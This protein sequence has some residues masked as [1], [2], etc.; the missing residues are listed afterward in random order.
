MRLRD[1][2]EVDQQGLIADAVNL[3]MMADDS[4]NLSLCQGFIFNY[5]AEKQKTSTLGVLDAL[6]E[7]FHSANSLNVHLMV[8][9]FGK[10][11]SHFALTLAN[12]FKKPADSPEVQGIL[13][14]VDLAVSGTANALYEKLKAYKQRSKT[15][16]V[17]CISGEVATDL[18]KMLLQG[19]RNALEEHGIGDAI[20]QHIIQEPL[21]YLR[22]LAG[23]KR[24]QAE[25][26]LEE[27]GKP[28]GDLESMT[29]LLA[30]DNYDIIPTVVE[31]SKQLETYAFNFEYNLDIEKIL[32]DVVT[33]LCTG[34][35]RR[36]EGVLILLDEINA[37]LRAWLKNSK[38]AGGAALQNITNVCERNRGRIALLC[39]AQ[40]KPSLDNQIPYLERKSYER[41]TTRIELAPSTYEP[42][43]SLELVIDNLLNQCDNSDWQDFHSQWG[44]TLWRESNR[45]YEQYI[46]AYSNRNWPIEDF[47]KHLGLGCYPLH[48]LTGYLLCNLEFT[49]GRTAIQFIKEDVAQFIEHKSVEVN[50]DLQFVRP[51]QLMDAF[52]SN[53]SLQSKYAEYEKAY[54]SIAASASEDELTM[55]KAIALYYLCGEKISKPDRERHDAILSVMTG[56]SSANT[57]HLLARL[58]DDYQ[59]VYYNAGSNTYRFFTGFSIAD[60]KRKIEEDTENKTPSFNDLLKHCRKN[61]PNYLGSETVRADRFATERRLNSADWQFAKEIFTIDQFERVLSSERSVNNSERGLVAYFIGEYDQ[62]LKAMEKEAELI[63]GK[64]PKAVRERIII[65]LPNRGT[66]DLAK[67][68]AMKDALS[69]KSSREK[70]EFGA[71]LTELNKQFEEQLD[72]ELHQIFDS[73]TYTCRII[74]K[75]PRAEIKHLE[76]IASKM[77]DELYT[78]VPPVESQDKLRTRSTAGSQVVSFASRQLLANDLKEPFPNNAYKNVIDPVFIRRWKLLK[79]GTPYTAMV[80]QD[81]NIR[82]AWDMISEL[83]DIGEKDQQSVEVSKIWKILSEAPYGHN[84]LTFTILFAAWLA[85]HRAEVELSGAFGIPKT[86]KDTVTVKTAP[87]YEWAQTNV[88][89]KAKDFISLWV[90]RGKNQVVRRKPLDVSVPRSVSYTDASP[91]IERIISQIQSGTLDPSKVAFLEKKQRQIQQGITVI[92]TWIQPT[93]E[94][95]QKLEQQAPLDV[96]AS[97]YAPLEITPPTI[98]IQDDVTTVRVA[99]DQADTWRQT[100]QALKDRIESLVEDLSSRASSFE[101]PEQGQ[102]L[103]KD[104]EH[105]IGKLSEVSELPTRFPDSLRSALESAAQRATQLQQLEKKRG[106]IEQIQRLYES[107]VLNAAQSQYSDTLEKI[108]TL[109]AAIPEVRQEQVYLDVVADIESKQD[110]LIRK[111]DEWESKFSSI[112]SVNE[113]LELSAEVTREQNRF[114]SEV[115]QQQVESLVNRIQNRILQQNDE[116]AIE[117]ELAAIVQKSRQKLESVSS[118]N[119]FN[120]AV[121]AYTELSQLALPK[122]NATNAESCQQQLKASQEEGEVAIRQRLEQLCQNCEREIKRADE[123]E[124]MKA[125]VLQAQRFVAKQA[126]LTNEQEKLQAAQQALE[127]RY[128]SL[129]KRTGDEAIIADIQKFKPGMGNTILRCEEIVEQIKELRSQLN[130]PEE[131]TDTTERFI[132]AFQGKRAEYTFSLDDLGVQLQSIETSPKLQ[133]LSNELSKLEF[134]FKDSTEYPRYKG[135]EDRLQALSKDL[136]QVSVLEAH[137]TS[138]QSISS[139][140]QALTELAESQTKLQDS[141]RFRAKLSVLEESLTQRYKQFIDELAQWKQ[142]LDYIAESSSARKVQTK[143]A[144]GASRYKDSEYAD[145]YDVVRTDINQLAQLLALADTQKVESIEAC[146]AEIDRLND[147]KGDQE[148]VSEAIEQRLQRIEK[149]LRQTQQTIET[150]QRNAAQKWLVGLQDEVTQLASVTEASEKLEKANAHL[151]KISLTRS[152]HDNFLED[153]QKDLLREVTEAYQLVQNQNRASKIE[154]LFKELPTNERVEL[155]QR[156]SAYLESTTEIF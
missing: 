19:L 23:E 94:A 112:G 11:K 50:G 118:L 7:S 110:G 51:V 4:K 27:I 98:T 96:L 131:H 114:D 17:I 129:Q 148:S 73:C 29:E 87:L 54:E 37:Y 134:V 140:K 103:L 21:R 105:K 75:I 33:K 144:N 9:D 71:A 116:I 117:T 16:L 89:E 128:S 145:N 12:F 5:D 46:T 91:L 82:Q 30:E 113:A 58:A 84:E 79:A 32:E 102:H 111:I 149:T 45:S 133:Q 138:A 76:P 67:V 61:L 49:Q 1:I 57:R 86:K 104:L 136:D 85:F 40:I 36:F 59:V 47:H 44:D 123:Y 52:A 24:E 26:Y 153:A 135:L 106:L 48:P 130:F 53:F 13:N 146:Q 63:L 109:A 3:K 42:R 2:V 34:E 147:W 64:A 6:R 65:A 68:L 95:Q 108:E 93:I 119:N 121:Q 78:Y 152:K 120:D 10:G 72:S 74:D 60:L 156:L 142:D 18:N 132:T 107:L 25:Q 99:E 141:D 77:L 38:A 14:R 69:S 20:A 83:T 97:Y 62:D 100:R 150:R 90:L 124:R 35:N 70:Q 101:T 88:L 92:N 139:I 31:I 39:M 22:G 41:F 28:F 151:K 66:R 56:F 80:P 8:Q 15:H 155:Y 126:E 81:P 137:V 43:A 115:N 122:A 143:V 154:T 55:L 125:D 127:E